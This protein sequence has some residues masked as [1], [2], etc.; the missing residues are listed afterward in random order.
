MATD[1]TLKAIEDINIFLQE[2]S[3]IR[4]KEK[5]EH[6]EVF[7][8]P[9][10]IDEML[11]TLPSSIWT[12]PDSV[13]IDPAAG[14]GNFTAR[15]LSGGNGY[16]GLYKSLAEKIP[17]SKKRLKHIFSKMIYMYDINPDNVKK[18]T[19][20]FQMIHGVPD[21]LNIFNEDFLEAD[22]P[23]PDVVLGNPPY[24]AGGIKRQGTKR[25]H[26]GFVEK[27]LKILKP[28]GALL[29][30]CPPNYR[31]AGSEMNRL[32]QESSGH[33]K[34]IRV[35]GPDETLQRFRIQARLDIFL[36]QVGSEGETRFINEYG[37]EEGSSFKLD[38][39]RHIPN[40]GLSIFDKMRRQGSLDIQA[41]RNTEATTVSCNKSK[42]TRRGKYPIIH[43]I[44]LGGRKVYN[45]SEPHS[46]QATPKLFLNGLGI[47]Y[48]Y[49]DADGKYGPSQTPVVVLEPSGRLVKF[50]Q[51]RF[52]QFIVWA[53]RLTG[54]NNL[55]YVFKDIPKNLGMKGLNLTKKE[56]EF[57]NS[58]EVPVFEDKDIL[59]TACNQ[60]R[61]ND[62]R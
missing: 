28:D 4:K 30:I 3:Q 20:L 39:T 51:S 34:Y 40:F 14:W 42:L 10:I 58:F 62:E 37:D 32:F 7:T 2:H 15:I 23:S 21:K 1:K 41:F 44:T 36:Y 48:V 17:D 46:L 56:I 52:F 25:I 16:P 13:W 54:N 9:D 29:F 47:P 24:N 33:F 59:Q 27:A 53:L 35:I 18:A 12:N 5:G 50:A 49:Y 57:I 38:L 11:A 55:P 22:T 6:G 61:K 45:R 19:E 8:P 26:V 31:E 60:T 43:L